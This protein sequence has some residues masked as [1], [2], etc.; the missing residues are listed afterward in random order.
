MAKTGSQI[1]G[2]IFQLLRV[3]D[4]AKGLTGQVYRFG[5]RP[6]DSKLEDAVVIFT[7][8][9]PTQVEEG[10]VTINIY[11]PDIDPYGNGVL[12][13]DGERA[14]QLEIA[15]QQ[16]VDSLTTSVSNYKFRLQMSIYTEEQPEINQHFV[17]IKLAYQYYGDES[18]SS[19]TNS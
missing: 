19:I 13:K 7:T 5:M 8:G 12:T 6:R 16:W 18:N 14:E 2:D 3:S 11:V 17:V 10:V 4:L 1:E 9:I 15:S